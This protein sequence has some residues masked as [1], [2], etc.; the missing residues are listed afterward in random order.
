MTTPLRPS[1]LARQVTGHQQPAPVPEPVPSPLTPEQVVES[2][3]AASA[4][5]VRKQFGKTNFF[6]ERLLWE[7]RWEEYLETIKAWMAG[8][9]SHAKAK[10]LADSAFERGTT[11]QERH[12]YTALR[13]NP[14]DKEADRQAFNDRMIEYAREKR[15]RRFWLAFENLPNNAANKED[16]YEW[17]RS[18][19]AMARKALGFVDKKTGLV[20]VGV[21]DITESSNGV[22]PSKAAVTLLLNY[23]DCPEQFWKG[24]QQKFNKKAFGDKPGDGETPAEVSD[25]LEMLK[26]IGG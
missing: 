10:A 11:Q 19:P 20:K 4:G 12:K 6:K 21:K 7:N 25:V 26:Q 3:K 9:M 15:E 18:H 17:V 22:A 13:T 1:D 2:R 23:K 14:E 5:L 8:G 16:E 24:D